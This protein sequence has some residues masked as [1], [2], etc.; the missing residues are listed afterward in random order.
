MRYLE[1]V[2][3]MLCE[4]LEK[5]SKEK[6][7]A[8]NLDVIDKITHSIKSIEA[9]MAMDEGG[10]SRRGSYGRSYD[11]SYDG[12]YE[13]SYDGGSYRRGRSATT[14]R[15]ISRSS[16][17]MYSRDYSRDD[18]MKERLEALMEE[19]TDDHTRQELQRLVDKM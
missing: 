11:G 6:L 18:G 17:R 16:G 8:G 13:G 12:S 1:D 14:G 19:A 2:K 15:Y 3:E 9:I 10:Y 5:I 7:N 4:E